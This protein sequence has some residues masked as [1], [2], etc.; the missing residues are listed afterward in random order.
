MPAR[1]RQML[2]TAYFPVIAF[3][4]VLV[5]ER[6]SRTHRRQLQAAPRSRRTSF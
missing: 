6:I 5:A 3:A 1:E 4:A 2:A